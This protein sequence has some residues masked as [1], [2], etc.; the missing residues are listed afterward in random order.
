[1]VQ[2]IT[3]RTFSPDELR[4]LARWIRDD[5]DPLVAREGPQA[6]AVDVVLELHETFSAFAADPHGVGIHMKSLKYS[7]IHRAVIEVASK[8]TRWPGRLINLCDEVIEC[9]EEI[10]GSLRDIPVLLYCEGGR[11]RGVVKP[12]YWTHEETVEQWNYQ[13]R[14]SRKLTAML[15]ESAPMNHGHLGFVPGQWW[16]SPI[17]AFRDGIISD[18]GTTAGIVYN[19]GGAYAIVLADQDEFESEDP[20][21][22]W[23]HTKPGD[24]GRYRLTSANESSRYPIRVLRSHTLHSPWAPKVGIRYDGLHR[25]IGWSAKLLNGTL[26][27]DIQVAREPDQTPIDQCLKRPFTD[28]REDYVEY[29]RLR[30]QWRIMRAKHPHKHK[31]QHR[32]TDTNEDSRI[33]PEEDFLVRTKITGVGTKFTKL[34]GQP[35]LPPEEGFNGESNSNTISAR[36]RTTTSNTAARL[37]SR[38]AMRR[39]LDGP[40]ADELFSFSNSSPNLDPEP[41]AIR[42][43]RTPAK[44]R[45]KITG[46]EVARL[47]S[48]MSLGQVSILN[49]AFSDHVISRKKSPE[50]KAAHDTTPDHSVIEDED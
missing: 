47:F 17:F 42:A 36:T 50:S 9:W 46:I 40:T 28:E 48:Q 19:A 25:V 32:T 38:T 13:S 6:L 39:S 37:S 23:F 21:T 3:S 15:S 27:Y 43:P 35:D 18:I 7:R 4:M 5:L 11:M 26:E 12:G 14:M 30:N 44:Q 24:R 10:F 8:A 33:T 31:R 45:L 49:A 1:M 34:I 41:K 16:I 2:L 20:N 22:F 29:R